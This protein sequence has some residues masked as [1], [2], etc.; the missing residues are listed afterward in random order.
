VAFS[1]FNTNLN[2]SSTW[3]ITTA[4]KRDQFA[5]GIKSSPMFPQVR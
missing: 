5:A 2:S 3:A 4:A 1:Y